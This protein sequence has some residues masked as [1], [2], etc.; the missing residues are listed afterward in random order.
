MT[1]VAE[2]VEAVLGALL[3]PNPPEASTTTTMPMTAS[4]PKPAQIIAGERPRPRCCAGAAAAAGSFGGRRPP[5][6][7]PLAAWLVVLPFIAFFR[8]AK[9]APH[10]GQNLASPA[11]LPHSGQYILA[12]PP[13]RR[14]WVISGAGA[15]SPGGRPRPPHVCGGYS[16]S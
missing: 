15:G 10:S 7:L 1:G 13:R 4:T 16:T 12:H 11:S 3:P 9:S 6:P 14:S 5:P 2:A 8:T